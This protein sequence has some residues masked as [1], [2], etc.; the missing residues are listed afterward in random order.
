MLAQ[1]AVGETAGQQA[2]DTQGSEQGLNTPVGETHTRDA[3]TGVRG[4][5]IGDGGQRGRSIGRVVAE[6]LGAQQAPVGGE[7]DLPQGGKVM[8]PFAGSESAGCG[9]W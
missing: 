2:E 3:L 9:W 1:V 5:G 4:H 8:Q 6:S 7:A